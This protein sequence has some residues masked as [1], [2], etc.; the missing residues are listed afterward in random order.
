MRLF[1]D[2]NVY[3]GFYNY[4][5]ED[6][7][8]LNKLVVLVE[9][10]KVTL[11]IT[12]QVKR[13]FRRNRAG[14]IADA[15]KKL[16]DH[17][18]GGAFPAFAKDYGEYEKLR[19]L[20]KQYEKEHAALIEKATDDIQ[21]ENLKADKVIAKLFATATTIE[22]SEELIKKAQ[23]RMQ[24]GDPPG[25]DDS[26]GDAINWLTLLKE[27]PN[28][29]DLFFISGDGDFASPLDDDDINEFLDDEWESEKHSSVL[30]HKRLSAFFQDKFP[31]IKV[32]VELEKQLLVERLTGSGS[33]ATTHNV[34]AALSNQIDD[35]SDEQANALAEAAINNNQVG[36]I[37]GDGDVHEFY[38]R[39]LQK[40]SEKLA[41][42]LKSQLEERLYPPPDPDPDPA[43]DPA[44]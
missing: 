39:L 30:F 42:E 36:W 21:A 8:E 14:K 35:F 19:E 11:Y 16:R 31:D 1:I 33:F 41:P 3:L 40:Y 28:N 27:V 43:G 4:T 32:A 24:I 37:I 29:E 18:L 17:K 10:K 2:T 5:S 7:E 12:E 15:Q 23:V 34:V 25:K 26:L 20:Q 44:F 38:E 13:E 9:Q 22:I 6:L